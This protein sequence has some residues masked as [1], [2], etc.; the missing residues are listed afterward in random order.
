MTEPPV[1]NRCTCL[2]RASMY[3]SQM[4]EAKNENYI[5]KF[6][7]L[8]RSLRSRSYSL[9]ISEGLLEF[10]NIVISASLKSKKLA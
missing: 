4:L 5:V 10:R 2:Y 1:A 3:N 8:K 6:V 9:L 7:K